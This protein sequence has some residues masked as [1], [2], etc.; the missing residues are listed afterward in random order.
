MMLYRD[1]VYNPESPAAGIAEINITKNRN[2]PLG[3]VYRRFWNG[4]FHY[5]DQAEARARSTER[6]EAYT[7]NK[8]YSKGRAA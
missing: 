7:S 2:G 4:H 1:E 8:R 6:E 5:I 3:T